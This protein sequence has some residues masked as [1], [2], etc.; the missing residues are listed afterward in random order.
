MRQ[1]VARVTESVMKDV[2]F[3]SLIKAIIQTTKI[4]LFDRWFNFFFLCS[5]FG[6]IFVP[7]KLGKVTIT[8]DTNQLASSVIGNSSLTEQPI[9]LLFKIWG[10]Y[11]FSYP[12]IPLGTAKA[13]HFYLY[14]FSV[15]V[16]LELGELRDKLFD[17]SINKC[18][19]NDQQ[20]NPS[21][22]SWHAL[23]CGCTQRYGNDTAR[24]SSRENYQ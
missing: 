10:S 24:D 17:T 6:Y 20:C 23:I 13:C 4:K 9:L 7:F 21:R 11:I 8:G 19:L 1:F 22:C 18:E 14:V 15:A 12:D 3:I 2:V 16:I 5:L